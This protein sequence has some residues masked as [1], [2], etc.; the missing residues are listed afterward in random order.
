MI[1][2][3]KKLK[4]NDMKNWI[5]MF[6]FKKIADLIIGYIKSKNKKRARIAFIKNRKEIINGIKNYC[7]KR[8][9][10]EIIARY[11]MSICKDCYAYTNNDNGCVVENSQPCCSIC[12]CSLE[13]KTRSLASSC[14]LGKWNALTTPDQEIQLLYTRTKKSKP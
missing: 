1:T 6:R 9:H 3:L 11:R 13:L 10:I 4:M 7:I 5:S 12:G 2:N 14:P 8:K